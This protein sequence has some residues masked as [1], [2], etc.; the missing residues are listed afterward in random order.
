MMDYY[1]GYVARKGCE[2][3]LVDRNPVGGTGS[4][5]HHRRALVL[6]N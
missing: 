3:R 2:Q 4:N 5:D 6:P 1:I